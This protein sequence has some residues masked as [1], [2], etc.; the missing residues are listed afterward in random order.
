LSYLGAGIPGMERPADNRLFAFA[1]D[2]HAVFKGAHARVCGLTDRQIEGRIALGLWQRLYDDVYVTAGAPLSWKGALLAACWA[3][4]FRAAASHRSAAALWGLAGGRRSIVEVTCP[5]WRRA[6]HEGLLV[7]ET[8]TLEG[9]DIAEVEGIPVTTPERT[10]LD[11]GAVCHES[12]VEMALDK[13]EHRRLVTRA[14]VQ[15]TLDR[16]GKSGRNGVGTLRR[17]LA[18]HGRERRAPESEMET[19]LIQCLRRNGWPDPIPQF[20]IHQTGKFVA[21]VDAA[22]PEWRIAIEYQSN[23]Y[24]SGRLASQRDNDRRLRI[25]AARWFPIEATLPDVRNGGTRLCAA[26]RA[27]SERLP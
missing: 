2:H 25:I 21:R 10:L 24:H 1:A 20:E 9:V 26:L 19:A 7:H 4:G 18:P 16:L 22:Y 3:G 8:K 13:A 12:V 27:G 17:L 23:E 5:R 6:Q 14:S 11:L 15:T